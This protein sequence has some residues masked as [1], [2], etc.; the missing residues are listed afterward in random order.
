MIERLR[1]LGVRTVWIAYPNLDFLDQAISPKVTRQQQEVYQSLKKGF[2][3]SQKHVVAR[4][5]FQEYRRTLI[6]PDR[7]HRRRSTPTR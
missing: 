7:G 1:D 3:T 5:D 2:G 4:V 6:G